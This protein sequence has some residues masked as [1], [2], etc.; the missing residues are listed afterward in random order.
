MKQDTF[1]DIPSTTS[2]V[3][4]HRR[5]IQVTRR[6]GVVL[7]AALLLAMVGA[8]V[9]TPSAHASGGGCWSFNTWSNGATSREGQN[10]TLYRD[11][12]GG[13]KFGLG[14]NSCDRTMLL[15]WS[16]II[17]FEGCPG[18]YYQIDWK[19]PGYDTW[20][21]FTVADRGGPTYMTST[22]TNVH[23]GTYYNFAVRACMS[24]GCESWSPTVGIYT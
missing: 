13:P 2:Q 3:G 22:F 8:F 11:N 12:N 20:Q 24:S 6:I 17:C 16:R 5:L 1:T 9:A 7:A 14:L 18:L 10:P 21:K 4:Y 23:L 15:K 19:R